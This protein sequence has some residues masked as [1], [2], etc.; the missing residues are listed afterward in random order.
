VCDGYPLAR[1]SYQ[2]YL[3]LFPSNRFSYDIRF[4][5]AEV[6]YELKQLEA[7]ADEYERVMAIDAKDRFFQIS[8]NSLILTM[9]KIPGIDKKPDAKPENVSTTYTP[10]GR[11]ADQKPSTSSPEPVTAARP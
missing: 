8:A 10:E 4:A 6:L 5:Y 2:K 7:V 3:G 1:K 9:D 11:T